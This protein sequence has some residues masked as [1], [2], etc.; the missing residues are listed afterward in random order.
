MTLL[1][2]QRPRLSCLPLHPGGVAAVQIWREDKARSETEELDKF[3]NAC[4]WSWPARKARVPASCH[5]LSRPPATGQ[6]RGRAATS[7]QTC[8]HAA[9]LERSLG[10]AALR[11]QGPELR[12]DERRC[13][14]YFDSSSCARPLQVLQVQ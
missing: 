3:L 4:G 2:A 14:P 1:C 6:P 8:S 7:A 9:A 5:L 12:L 10:L 11:P 13:A